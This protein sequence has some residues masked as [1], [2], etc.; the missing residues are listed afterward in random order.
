MTPTKTSSLLAAAAWVALFGATT[1]CGSETASKD[2]SSTTVG[3]LGERLDQTGAVTAPDPP[4]GTDHPAATVTPPTAVEI[5]SRFSVDK[6][7]T[8]TGRRDLTS[9]TA[10]SAQGPVCRFRTSNNEIGFDVAFQPSLV[11]YRTSF[12]NG[13]KVGG[14]VP[15][16]FYTASGSDARVTSMAREDQ[17]TGGAL[18]F[19][20]STLAKTYFSAKTAQEILDSVTS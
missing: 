6:L 16:Q 5:C 12:G 10:E 4:S 20:Q 15:I 18:V 1:A 17:L 8:V 2:A 11:E 14:E 3:V 13:T 9:E 7:K 19:V